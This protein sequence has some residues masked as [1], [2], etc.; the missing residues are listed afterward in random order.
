M[1]SGCRKVT[2]RGGCSSAV[3]HSVVVRDVAGSNPVSR[4]IYSFYCTHRAIMQKN[5]AGLWLDRFPRKKYSTHK[6]DCGHAI[7]F[8]AAE[9]TGASRLAA[10]S[11]AR[12]GAGMV[13]VVSPSVSADV[14]RASLP[15]H[16]IVENLSEDLSAHLEDER[17]NAVLIGPGAG[18][19]LDAL[20]KLAQMSARYKG[21]ALVLDADALNAIGEGDKGF[22]HEKAILTPHAGEFARLF[23][24][25]KDLDREEQVRA[26]TASFRGVLVLKGTDTLIAQGDRL[27]VNEGAPPCLATAGTGDV[28]AGIITGLVAQGMPAFEAACAGVWIH[29]KAAEKLGAGLVASDLEGKIP[30]ILRE[31]T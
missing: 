3:E 10:E 26:A 18:R 12:I 11:C 5:T 6:Y 16:I 1:H 24:D 31:I 30:E 17:R 19:D 29:A 4:P 25:L 8:G 13:S 15:P 9:M 27:V 2:A 22:L 28:L 20:L 7:I 14:Y 21:R 23:P